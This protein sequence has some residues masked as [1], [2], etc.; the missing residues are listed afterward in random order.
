MANDIDGRLRV[1]ELEVSRHLGQCEER[2]RDIIR[3]HEEGRSDR[4]QLRVDLATATST[5]SKEIALIN[6]KMWTII[7]GVASSAIAVIGQFIFI[8]VK[9]GGMHG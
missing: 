1:L 9:S 8:F 6:K 7:L 4:S 5:Q 3:R 2:H